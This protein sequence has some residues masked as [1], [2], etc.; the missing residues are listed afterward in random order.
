M[1]N[2]LP[3]SQDEKIKMTQHKLLDLAE[4]HKNDSKN[5]EKDS[6][7]SKER[8]RILNDLFFKE[9]EF[10]IP[11]VSLDRVIG[12]TNNI[13]FVT[14]SSCGAKLKRIAKLN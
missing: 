14:T 10:F 4:K 5:F 13:R 6:D 8:E 1:K 12:Y 2:Y 11:N 9:V 7:Y 3:L